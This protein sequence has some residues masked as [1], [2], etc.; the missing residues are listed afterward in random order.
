MRGWGKWLLLLIGMTG[1]PL[2]MGQ[3]GC[4]GGLVSVDEPTE[5]RIGQQSAADLERQYGVTTTGA[6]AARV[7]RIGFAIARVS[8]RPS[9][10][11]SFKILNMSDVNALSL[12]GGPVY[13]TS[14]LINLGVSDAELAGVLGHEVAHINQRHAV[15]A[16]QRAMTEQ[17]LSQLIL[18]NSQATQAAVN[19]ALQY[20]Y[21][22]PH[23][24]QDEYEADAVGTKL[25]YNAGFPANGL[26]A[27]LQRLQQISG[28]SRTLAWL[29]THPL[30]E[31]RVARER[32]EVAQ[33]QGQP[34]PVPIALT[35][36]NL[37]IMRE[38]A[39]E[40][41]KSTAATKQEVQPTAPN[42]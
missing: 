21:E 39:R 42:Q 15:K 34:R 41:E 14:G 3:G 28:P 37:K 23:S 16:I 36:E 12:P 20:A 18:G 30:T 33:L 6:Q 9:L 10:P 35:E 26:L 1:L 22:L 4:G 8:Q 5:I 32:T 2:L 17:L 25:A 11:W 31:D 19:V 29:Q 13:V 38:L 40:D 7:Q 27:F 24:R